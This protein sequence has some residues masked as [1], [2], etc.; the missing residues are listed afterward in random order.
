[1]PSAAAKTTAATAVSTT[2]IP[3]NSSSVPVGHVAGTHL[4]A[5]ITGYFPVTA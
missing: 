5:D 4:I 2:E 1:V 3:V